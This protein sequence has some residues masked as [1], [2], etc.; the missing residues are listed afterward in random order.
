[1]QGTQRPVRAK[2]VATLGPA[3]ESPEMVRRL[4]EAGVA[5]FRLNFS[6]GGAADHLKR[7]MAVRSVAA[8][9][10]RPVA[11]MGDLCGPKIRV[12]RVPQAGGIELKAGQDVELRRGID[13]AMVEGGTVVLPVTYPE[14][15]HEALPGQRVLINDGAVRMLAVER[16]GDGLRCRVIVGGVVSS[17]KGINL[18]DSA[19]SATAITEQDWKNVE[20]AV[21]HGLD[22]LALSF[23]RRAEEVRELKDRL[24]GMCP[25]ERYRDDPA[26]A[27]LGCGIPVVAKRSLTPHGIPSTGLRSFP[28]IARRSAARA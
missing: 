18:P 25:V 21:E 13:A 17:G 6:H 22:F 11:V 1:M 4:I 24:C 3:S 2:I 5:V 10:A 23:V 28:F 20:W 8:E 15:I 27:E 14:L 7:L 19:I 9:M 12:G 16:D 26:S